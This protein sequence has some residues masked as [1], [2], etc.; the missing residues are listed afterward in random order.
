MNSHMETQPHQTKVTVRPEGGPFIMAIEYPDIPSQT[1]VTM[2]D[3][4]DIDVELTD[5][6]PVRNDY[7]LVVT[8]VNFDGTKTRL[9][10]CAD[11]DL[12]KR[13][14]EVVAEEQSEVANRD[15]EVL[16]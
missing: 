3:V 6:E 11:F 10:I 15:D 7:R 13:L 8:G 14:A 5:G 9:I 16:S 1:T 2:S 12:L 4:K